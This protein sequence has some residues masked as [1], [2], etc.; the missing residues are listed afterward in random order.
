MTAANQRSRKARDARAVGGRNL[1]ATNAPDRSASRFRSLSEIKAGTI[2][3]KREPNE[4]EFVAIFDELTGQ[5]AARRNRGGTD[6]NPDAELI[7]I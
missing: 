1:M 5:W 4:G 7:R 6:E 2:Y 3:A